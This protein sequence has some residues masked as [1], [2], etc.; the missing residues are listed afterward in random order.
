GVYP[1]GMKIAAGWWRERRGMAIGVVIGA[2]TLG[3]AAPNLA[4]A[5][6][7]GATWRQVLLIAA[8]GALVAA[9]LFLFAVREGPY[10]ARSQPFELRALARVLGNPGV[11]LATGGYLG[12]MWELYAMWSGMAAFWTYVGQQRNLSPAA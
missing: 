11:R 2:L 1:P 5:L 8:L 7:S 3:S 4:R 10:Q 12:H 6:V 9:A